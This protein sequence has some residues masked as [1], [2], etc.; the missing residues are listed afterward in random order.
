MPPVGYAF[1]GHTMHAWQRTWYG[2]DPLYTPLRP[3]FV[4]RL[5]GRCDRE[6]YAGSYGAEGCNECGNGGD[7]RGYVQPAPAAGIWM[8]LQSERLGQIPNDMGVGGALP[9]GAPGR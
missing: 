2:Q 3:Y 8:P 5:P 6:P 1:H 4:P 7:F 9:V